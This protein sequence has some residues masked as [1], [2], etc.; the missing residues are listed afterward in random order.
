MYTAYFDDFA[1]FVKEAY[2]QVLSSQNRKE[3]GFIWIRTIAEYYVRNRDA[4]I[5]TLI[6]VFNN[7]NRKQ[8]ENEF[9]SRGINFELISDRKKND[10]SYPSK[11]HLTMTTLIFSVAQYH[12]MSKKSGE[13]PADDRVKSILAQIESRITKGLD[14]DAGRVSAL[15][16]LALEQ[17]AAGKVYED[18]ENNTLL[19]A[20]AG[21]VAEAG[22]WDASMEMVAKRSGLSKSGL[23]AHFKNKQD[24]LAQL[25]ITEF[26]RIINFAK[27]QIEASKIP[28]EQ[29][30]IAIISIVNYLRSRPEILVIMDWIKTGRLELGKKV[31]GRLDRI[32]KNIAADV[33]QKHDKQWLVWIAQWILFMIVNT[34]AWWPRK[35]C[36]RD[37]FSEQNKD[38]AKNAAEIP[39][40]SFRILF[41]FIALG[42]EG[43]EQ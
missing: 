11:I 20:V 19:R 8:I 18:T 7:R 16:Y 4:F 35:E 30:Y 43:L 36:G 17:R 10:T 40:E 3:S 21:A 25:F 41:R 38:W 22:P 27:T 2:G 6:Q 13:I 39:N 15:D 5:F 31:T 1:F 24:M 28:E 23:Y 33:I 26:S 34:L 37:S 9:N 42:L 32:I 12:H 14:L 29:L